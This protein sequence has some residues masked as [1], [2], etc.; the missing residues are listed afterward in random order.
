MIE[1]KRFSFV[2]LLIFVL[3]QQQP[4]WTHDPNNTYDYVRI[5]ISSIDENA[6]DYTTQDSFFQTISAIT[7]A[8]RKS[9]LESVKLHIRTVLR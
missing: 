6:D 7:D 2:E 1:E 5:V 9:V 3:K 4:Q 8:E